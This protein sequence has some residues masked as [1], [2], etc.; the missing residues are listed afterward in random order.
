MMGGGAEVANG[1]AANDLI[2]MFNVKVAN[3]LALDMKMK[4]RSSK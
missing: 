2:E 1:S 4:G 3:D